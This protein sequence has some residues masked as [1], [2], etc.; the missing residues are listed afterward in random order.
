MGFQLTADGFAKTLDALKE[1]YLI[2]APVLKEGTG[3]FTDTDIVRYDF[4]SE[5]S[6]IELERKSDYAFKE[7]LTPLSE[8]LLFF[9]EDQVKAADI[10][11]KP[12]LIFLRSCDLHAVRRQDDMYLNNGWTPDWF[13]KRRRDLVKFVLIGCKQSYQNCFCVSMGSN[14]SE[15]GY[16]FSVEPNGDGYA[17]DVPDESFASFFR[18][19]QTADIVP[20]YVLE[21]QFSVRVPDRV[22]NAILKH[23]LWDEYSARCIGC[24]RCNYVCP[25]CTCY[26]M[27]DIFY[28]EN[29]KVGERRRVAAACMVDG[30]TNV[31][32]G[33]EYRKSQGERMRYRVLHKIS[34]HKKRFGEN[35]CIGCGRCDDACPEYISYSNILNKVTDAVS[36]LGKEEQ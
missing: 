8:T 30:F 7:F 24:G 21:N 26:T 17:C 5:A 18:D 36:C 32:G 25:T 1:Q 2:Y 19:G 15:D 35:M 33:G 16:V 23:P 34:D 29:G 12:V 22:P 11:D 4:V 20:S 31:A 28:N 14:R 27:Q 3:R 6:E 10:P 9:T 13:F